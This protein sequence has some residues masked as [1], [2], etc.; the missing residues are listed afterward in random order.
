MSGKGQGLLKKYQVS[1]IS[2]PKKDL[3]CIVLE[4][5]DPIAR[6]GLKAWAHAMNDAGYVKCAQQTLKKIRHYE[7]CLHLIVFSK[8]QDNKIYCNDC[9]AVR[10]FGKGFQ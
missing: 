10:E 3:D 9:P 8:P 4:F 5:D 1:K 7:P 2:N 6:E